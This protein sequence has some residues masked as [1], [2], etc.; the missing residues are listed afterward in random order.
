M[1]DPSLFMCVEVI[2]L[3]DQSAFEGMNTGQIFLAAAR[4]PQMFRRE[5]RLF[6]SLDAANEYAGKSSTL[7][8]VPFVVEHNELLGY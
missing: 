6:E 1:A 8:V 3:V 4:L 7:T 5:W 2:P